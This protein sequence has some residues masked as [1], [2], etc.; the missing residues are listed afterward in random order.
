MHCGKLVIIAAASYN[1]SWCHL[2]EQQIREALPAT[3]VLCRDGGDGLI[4]H[5]VNS[6][7]FYFSHILFY[8]I[9]FIEFMI[10]LCDYC[11]FLFSQTCE[12]KGK[13]SEFRSL[14]M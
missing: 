12:S 6:I 10:F 11:E 14:N 7:F 2:L 1:H 13:S 4:G 9:F 8:M 3:V 5:H